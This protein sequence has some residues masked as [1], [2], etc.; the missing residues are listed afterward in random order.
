MAPFNL[1]GVDTPVAEAFSYH[2]M[3][4][5]A[6]IVSAGAIV[7]TAGTCFTSMVGQNRIFLSMARDVFTPLGLV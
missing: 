3:D 1:L 2:G 6:Q 5:A 4:W 7:G